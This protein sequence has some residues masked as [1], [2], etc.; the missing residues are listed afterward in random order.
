MLKIQKQISF[1]LL[2]VFTIPIVFQS[3][4]MLQHRAHADCHAHCGKSHAKLHHKE[5]NADNTKGF[6]LVLKA[7][8][9]SCPICDYKFT[10]KQILV[11]FQV[12]NPFNYFGELSLT[13]TEANL[14]YSFVFGKSSRAPP[15]PL[16]V[17]LKAT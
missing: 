17:F 3:M 11:D 1:I 16:P 8:D 9:E 2:L 12:G 6:S 5:D 14:I 4:H 10:V 15:L 7:A 13:F